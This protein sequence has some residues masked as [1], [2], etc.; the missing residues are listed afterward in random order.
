[1]FESRIGRRPRGSLYPAGA[2]AGRTMTAVL[3]A[4]CLAPAAV[5]AP[6]G[7]QGS[8]PIITSLVRRVAVF[9]S[10]E[11]MSLPPA[12]RGLE[13]AVGLLYETRSRSVCTAFCVGDS[14]IATAA[15]C[16]HRTSAEKPPRLSDFTF[17]I[18]GTAP[19]S[20]TRIAG[21]LSGSA[22]QHV[23]SGS[24]HLSIHP[25]IDASRDWAFV[26]LAGPVCKGASLR[27]SRRPAK[28]LVKL[29]AANRVYQVAFHR[30]FSNWRLA[31]GAPC[32]VRRSFETADWASISRD[33]S[34]AEQ[35]I[36]H[37]CDTGGA[38]SGSPLLI[39]GPSGPEVVGINVG[40]Y[41]QSR[42]LMQNGEVIRRYKADTVANTGVSTAAFLAKLEAFERAEILA[43]RDKLR[44][45][46]ELL[47]E[48]GLYG[49][50][51]D[52]I[53]GPAIRAAIEGFERSEGR[54]ETGLATTALLQRL[55][56]LRAER[57]N[58]TAVAKSPRV[59]TGSVGTHEPA[60]SRVPEPS[61]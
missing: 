7:V 38:S 37:T 14:V 8:G 19:R 41:V 50:P 61:R 1:M 32:A 60:S 40:T 13:H 2:R 3:A 18:V 26:R 22:G 4:S 51:A 46:Q 16:V 54:P 43:T 42:V 53:Y 11:R 5:A 21:A 15:H 55:T 23:M 59:E 49:G 6:A 39:D 56:V 58:E 29:S 48:R 9:G 36:L 24:M 10:D 17:R 34:E 52:A 31:Y 44:K 35:L 47:A 30:D 12:Y 33:F 28:D 57:G 45:L 20:A 27:I 25:P